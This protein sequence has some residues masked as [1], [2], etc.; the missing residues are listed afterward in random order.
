M[1][2]SGR[3][4]EHVRVVGQE[5]RLA[6]DEAAYPAQSLADRRVQ[7]GVDERDPPVGDVGPEQLDLAGAALEDEIVGLGLV[8]VQ[9]EV[10]DR[11][12]AVAEAEHE[13]GVPEMRVVAHHMPHEGTV[14]DH[15]HRLGTVGDPV[16]HPH[17]EATAEK[18]DLH[19][20]HPHRKDFELGDREDELSAPRRDVAELMADLVAQVPR[21]DEDVVGLGLG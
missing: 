2:G 20:S 19:D 13:I 17:P 15:R 21:Q 3:V 7:P 8:V 5:H 9:E 11:G 4:R 6:V 18:Y 12:R 16:T 14:P 1:S 10:L